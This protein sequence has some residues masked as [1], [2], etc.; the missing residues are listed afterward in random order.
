M[1]TDVLPLESKI[2]ISLPSKTGM[3]SKTGDS[4]I[5]KNQRLSDFFVKNYQGRHGGGI[6]AQ[7]IA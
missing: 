7:V 6:L 5:S 2:E 1:N 4:I 3:M